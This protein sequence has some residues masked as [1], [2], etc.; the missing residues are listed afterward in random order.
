MPNFDIILQVIAAWK[1]F[2]AD[3]SFVFNRLRYL[4]VLPRR[5]KTK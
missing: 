1:H 3:L 2:Q 4:S 5:A